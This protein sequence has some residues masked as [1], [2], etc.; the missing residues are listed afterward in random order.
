MYPLSKDQQAKAQVY[1]ALL[2]FI[3]VIV[4]SVII[5]GI[6]SGI[7]GYIANT[8]STYKTITCCGGICLN[9]FFT[10]HTLYTL[11][12]WFCIIT[13]FIGI[14]MAIHKASSI[15]FLHYRF[16][17]SI[18]PLSIKNHT[19]LKRVLSGIYAHSQTI[20]LDTPHV[21]CAFTS[22]IWNPRI[23]LSTGICSYLTPK[24]LLAV[25]LHEI[26]HKKNRAP[27][28]LFILQIF[29]AINFYLPINNYLI[30][31]YASA[32]EKAA[33]DIAIHISGEP[34][35]LAS[36]L[37]KLSQCSATEAQY[38]SVAFS[39]EQ[40]ITEDRLRRLLVPE[41]VSTACRKRYLYLPSL[42][43]LFITMTI[44]MA[45]FYKPFLYTNIAE[46]KASACNMT[47]CELP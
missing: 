13:L 12:P 26:H 42:L 41:S 38:F 10:L 16:I 4:L 43:S 14:G 24:E 2:L 23:Y 7:N 17:R 18:T 3:N 20:L 5:T 30:N 45:L 36:A 8:K 27:L 1:F 11:F 32:S 29:R 28:K 34:L 33:D 39:K 37:V 15:L 47:T 6:I 35:E 46:C 22:G 25:I 21:V 31:L 44:C 19:K 40:G 9:C